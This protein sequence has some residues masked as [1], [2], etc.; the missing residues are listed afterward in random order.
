MDELAVFI[1]PEKFL[2]QGVAAL[3]LFGRPEETP[4]LDVVLAGL[5]DGT[6]LP[7]LLFFRGATVEVPDGFP[8]NVLLEARPEGFSEQERLSIWTQKVRLRPSVLSPVHP[9]ACL[10]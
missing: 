9:P 7:P 10:I 8:E 6:F 4:M 5:S 3:Q 1:H 2:E